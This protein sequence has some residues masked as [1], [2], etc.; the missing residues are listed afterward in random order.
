MKRFITSISAVGLALMALAGLPNREVRVRDDS[1]REENSRCDETVKF[2][3]VSSY[4]AMQALIEKKRLEIMKSARTGKDMNFLEVEVPTP[5]KLAEILDG[6]ANDV[7]SLVVTGEI[8]AEDIETLRKLGVHASLQVLNLFNAHVVEEEIPYSAFYNFQDQGQIWHEECEGFKPLKFRRV[9]LPNDIK[10]IDASAFRFAINLE[11][12]NIPESC[13]EIGINCFGECWYLMTNPLVFPEGLEEIPYGCCFR[14][15]SIQEVVLPSTIKKI[16]AGAFYYNDIHQIDFPAE[17]EYLDSQALMGN[18]LQTVVLPDKCLN[19]VGNAVFRKCKQLT[20]IK[21]PEGLTNIP[22]EFLSECINLK[23]INFPSS[24]ESIG[25][26]AFWECKSLFKIVLPEGLKSIGIRS[27]FQCTNVRYLDLPSTLQDIGTEAF[28]Y[29]SDLK[30][31][32]C[33]AIVP[34][35]FEKGTHAFQHYGNITTPDNIPVYIPIGTKEIYENAAGW[36]YF[37]NFIET[38]DF[39]AAMELIE[40]ESNIRRKNQKMYNLNGIEVKN[41]NERGLIL[42]DGRKMLK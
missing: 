27:F 30:A 11:D 26:R 21:L 29:L 40:E 8:N 23:N 33:R 4:S 13:R 7:D 39:T 16:G 17:L 19:Y 9:M 25:D 41:P 38:D 32:N 5:G 2:D 3:D 18:P 36:S 28:A 20:D 15:N 34:P 24:I 14:C 6:K 22:V 10:R 31:I 12:I 35:L 37:T 42:R 1:I